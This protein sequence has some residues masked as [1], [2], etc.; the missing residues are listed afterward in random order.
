VSTR[1]TIAAVVMTMMTTTAALTGA[2][3]PALAAGVN[4]LPRVTQA[5]LTESVSDLDLQISYIRIQDTI[6]DVERVSQQGSET[7][8][9]LTTDILFTFGK[10]ELP[11]SATARIVTLVAKV[12]RGGALSV[13][14]HTDNVGST[15][16]NLAL[17]K[18]RAAAVASVIAT[19]RPDIRLTVRGLGEGRPA[20]TNETG[21]TDDPAGRARNRRVELRY[22]G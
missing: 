3:S 2:A 12:P 17:S 5:E 15:G 6:H 11:T 13:E 16:S 19:A 1:R 22:K 10:A 18:K 9:T 4:D 8:V 14:G 21:G 7:V 20:A